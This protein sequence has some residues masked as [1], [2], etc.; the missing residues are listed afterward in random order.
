MLL[1]PT[2]QLLD[3]GGAVASDL[4]TPV[5][6]PGQRYYLAVQNFNSGE[7]NDFTLCVN[8]DRIDEKVIVLTNKIAFTNTIQVTSKIDYYRFT[9]SPTAYKA[10]FELFPQNGNVDLVIHKD[11]P[12]PTQT[13]FDFNSTNLGTNAEQIVVTSTNRPI[14]LVPGDW[15]LGVYNVDTNQ[16]TYSVVVT[17]LT[18]AVN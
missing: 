18:N 10:T 5:L 9:V 14:G 15:Y 13:F 7:T 8:F 11:F 6:L 2:D 17:E 3:I 16:V 12:L 4:I 1:S